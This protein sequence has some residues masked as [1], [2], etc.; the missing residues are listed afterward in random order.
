MAKFVRDQRD[1][2]LI[3]SKLYNELA[4]FLTDNDLKKTPGCIIN[5]QHLYHSFKV[6]KRS[7]GG[8]RYRTINAPYEKLKVLQK[9]LLGHLNYITS[10]TMTNTSHGFRPKRNILTNALSHR[11]SSSSAD[12]MT[13]GIVG[14]LVFAKK[15]YNFFASTHSRSDKFL[16]MV[17]A[18]QIR[19]DISDAFG[20][21]DWSKIYRA[22]N[23]EIYTT[24][25]GTA[26]AYTFREVQDDLAII[27]AFCMYMNRL[28]QGA[29][30]SPILLNIALTPLDKYVLGILKGVFDKRNNCKTIYTRYADDL[31]I[32]CNKPGVA[33]K[34][35]HLVSQVC[36]HYGYRVNNKKTKIMSPSTGFFVTGI[37]VV[38]GA[39]HISVSRKNRAK[40]RAAIFEAHLA[41]EGRGKTKLKEQVRGRIAHV[42]SVDFIHG[43]KL[44][45]YARDLGVFAD[46]PSVLKQVDEAMLNVHREDRKFK[47]SEKIK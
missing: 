27:K 43:L 7:G 28:P 9:A 46:K 1:S 14:Q 24:P 23:S 36:K 3:P 33:K 11:F 10:K 2:L 8:R 47:F 18:S 35:I 13:K 31:T 26:P 5:L 40:V 25:P 21:T 38:N 45:V 30:T 37:N 44:E 12:M 15:A 41:P 22:F 42:K 20:S 29:P 16:E 6:K 34:A 32:S 4:Q 19:M 17:P 39:D